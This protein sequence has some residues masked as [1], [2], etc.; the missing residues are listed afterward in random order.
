MNRFD[1]FSLEELESLSDAL[2]FDRID[3]YGISSKLND[4]VMLAYKEKKLANVS[5]KESREQ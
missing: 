2:M 5:Q 1:T 4:E 3:Q